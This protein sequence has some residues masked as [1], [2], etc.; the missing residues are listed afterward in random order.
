MFSKEESKRRRE[1]FWT[2]F[3]QEY[4]R[5]WI[6]YNTKIKEIQFKFSFDRKKAMV[7][8]DIDAEDEIIR[9]YYFEKIQSLASILK[10]TYLPEV[11]LDEEYELPEGKIVSRVY[12]MLDAKV[13]INNKNDWP[14]V[15]TFFSDHMHQLELFWLEFKDFITA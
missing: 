3:G 15:K 1:E 10:S 2:S 8:L 12:V 13:S 9:G 4:S 14:K 11:I 7:S 5:K 6:L